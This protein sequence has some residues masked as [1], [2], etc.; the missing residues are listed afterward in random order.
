MLLSK[1]DIA[2]LRTKIETFFHEETW[3]EVLLFLLFLALSLGF[4]L[5]QSVQQTDELS[6]KI[7]LHYTHL[8]GN[9]AVSSTL[10][11]AIEVSVQGAGRAL[12][13][14]ALLRQQPPIQIDLQQLNP[15]EQHYTISSEYIATECLKRLP[16][17]A[18]MIS[19]SPS[20]IVI[21]Y[22]LL[23]QK[24][25]PVWLNG[26]IEPA[27]GY[28][29]T[30]HIVFEPSEVTVYGTQERLDSIHGVF[31]EKK[32]WSNLNS[33]KK[34]RMK[35]QAVTGVRLNTN[36]VNMLLSVEEYTEKSFEV[37]VTGKDFPAN[38]RL[39][40]FPATIRISCLLPLSKYSAIR[41]GDFEA[42]VFYGDI[43]KNESPTVSVVITQKPE[44]PD[45]YQYEP[46]RVEYLIE[47]IK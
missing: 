1:T 43:V 20:A 34:I 45:N 31:T 38:C 23:K 35:L 25:V 4:W 47:Q 39:R 42:S 19:C 10:P 3:K 18:K 24:K 33:N 15:K 9:I 12:L 17:S 13:K 28:M 32:S 21:D 8:P 14:Y 27:S 22:T 16:T 41:P 5:M 44:V 37:P 40:T 36:A 7:P 26:K 11:T 6:V 29:L 46:K 30:K 2:N